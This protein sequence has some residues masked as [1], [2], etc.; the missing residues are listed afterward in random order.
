MIAVP[1]E[2]TASMLVA[3]WWTWP[4]LVACAWWWADRRWRWTWLLAV[5]KGIVGTL[6]ASVG[7]FSLREFPHSRPLVATLW[8]AFPAVL[9]ALSALNR[10]RNHQRFRPQR[11][12]LYRDGFGRRV[13]AS[14]RRWFWPC[15]PDPGRPSADFPYLPEPSLGRR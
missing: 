8:T 13:P 5:T 2:M 6:W 7:A 9:A 11:P 10:H 12:D 3:L 14:S 15:A 1:L 4:P